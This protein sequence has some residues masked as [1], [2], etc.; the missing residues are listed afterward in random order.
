MI[1]IYWTT[2]FFSCYCFIDFKNGHVY[3]E[4]WNKKLVIIK[5]LEEVVCVV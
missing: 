3:Y 4:E 1:V 5:G 2:L